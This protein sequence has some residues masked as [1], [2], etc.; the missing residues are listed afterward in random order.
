[1]GPYSHPRFFLP[2]LYRGAARRETKFGIM[3]VGGYL[4]G[5]TLYQPESSPE[6][7]P[8]RTLV[9]DLEVC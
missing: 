1:M 2:R 4:E 9:C 3:I 8:K 7:P 5:G 6:V